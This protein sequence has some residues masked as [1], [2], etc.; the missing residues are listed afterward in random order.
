MPYLLVE[1]SGDP[2]RVDV[3]PHDTDNPTAVRLV[4]VCP[5][6]SA[7]RMLCC[8]EAAKALAYSI[9]N[10]HLMDPSAWSDI[11]NEDEDTPIVVE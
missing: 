9:P 5:N 10:F 7:V 11:D 3:V 4:G 1:V 2:A 8:I 6:L